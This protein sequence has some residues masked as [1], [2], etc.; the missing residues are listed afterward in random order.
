MVQQDAGSCR[1]QRVAVITLP[2]QNLSDF[3]EKSEA[4]Q[5]FLEGKCVLGE[6][7]HTKAASHT[8]LISRSKVMC[9]PY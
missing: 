9:H 2:I 3:H 5:T 6:A 4:A 1:T 7:H 8:W